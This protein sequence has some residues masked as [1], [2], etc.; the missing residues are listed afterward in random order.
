M[1]EFDAALVRQAVLQEKRTALIEF[2]AGW[3]VFSRLL[4]PKTEALGRAFG[5]RALVGRLDA[6]RH[7]ALVRDLGIEFLP[8][9]GFFHGGELV[10]K[11]Y[12]DF[13]IQEAVELLRRHS[14]PGP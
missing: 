3:C 9:M 10:R 5:D 4:L 14:P 1:V 7:E 12:G 11:W 6:E 8:A 2:W 13:P